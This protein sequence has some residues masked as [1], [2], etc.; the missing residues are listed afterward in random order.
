[1]PSGERDDEG[2]DD[3]RDHGAASERRRVDVDLAEALVVAVSAKAANR[4]AAAAY[5]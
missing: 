4:F 2:N 5:Y 3:R 1:V